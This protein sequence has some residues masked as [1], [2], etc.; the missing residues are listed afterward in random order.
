[1]LAPMS[2]LK[3]VKTGQFGAKLLT[4]TAVH[5]LVW[6]C[7]FHSR[8]WLFFVEGKEFFL[9]TGAGDTLCISLLRPWQAQHSCNPASRRKS[10]K[11]AQPQRRARL[12]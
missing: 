3:I 1:M 7:P 5:A 2:S 12:G 6:F 8:D 9:D 4:R 11:K 10:G